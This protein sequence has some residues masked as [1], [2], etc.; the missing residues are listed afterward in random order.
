MTHVTTQ[1]PSL[2]IAIERILKQFTMFQRLQ[3]LFDDPTTEI[4]LLF[5]QSTLP[6]FTH[7][8]KLLHRAEP[9]VY[10]FQPQLLSLMISILQKFIQPA[11]LVAA[12]HDCTLSSIDLDDE[13][14]MSLTTSFWLVSLHSKRLNNIPISSQQ[15]EVFLFGLSNTL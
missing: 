14:N 8:N 1:W 3:P 15:L 10:V 2:E 7:A 11:V 12:I 4:Y 9:L 6:T 13:H 5:F